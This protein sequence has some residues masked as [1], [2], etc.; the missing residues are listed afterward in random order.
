LLKLTSQSKS[1]PKDCSL[2]FALKKSSQASSEIQT[3]EICSKLKT[4]DQK[5]KAIG[6]SI[7]H[8]ASNNKPNLKPTYE[9]IILIVALLLLIILYDV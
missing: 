9:L 2:Y 7:E 3:E 8:K 5:I 4:I 1:D 6:Q